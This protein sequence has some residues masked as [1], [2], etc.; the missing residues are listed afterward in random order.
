MYGLHSKSV[1]PLFI[2]MKC[3]LFEDRG[4]ISL[5]TKINNFIRDKNDVQISL[6]TSESGYDFYY[7]A[8]VYRK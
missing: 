6:S 3:K 7:T 2:T 8:I 4:M 1:Y 5:E